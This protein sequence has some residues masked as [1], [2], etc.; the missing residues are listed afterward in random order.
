MTQSLSIVMPAFNESAVI[1]RTVRECNDIILSHF[2]DGEIIVVDDHS[3]DNT[4]E[5]L[6]NLRDEIPGLTVVRNAANMGH[7]PSM[8]RGLRMA[9]GHLVFCIDSDYQHPPG[10]FWKLFNQADGADI[11]IGQRAE[12]RDPLHRRV[13][14]NMA[15]L[16]V[17][18]LFACP[19]RDVNIPFK[20][21]KRNALDMV[22]DYIPDDSLIPSILIMAVACRLNLNIKQ[23]PVIHLPRTTGRCSLPGRRLFFF[24]SRAFGEL[25]RFRAG[26]WRKLPGPAR[27]HA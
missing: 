26:M 3:S 1:A 20:L 8:L 25:L 9:P 2:P 22:L 24:A 7:G 19:V 14:S 23:V 17:R 11:V 27:K 12:R 15:N 5:V 6:Q 13:L 21:F 16:A 4:H 18:G 10:E